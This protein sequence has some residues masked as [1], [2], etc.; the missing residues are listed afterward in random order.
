MKDCIFCKIMNGEIPSKVVYEDNKVRA[1]MDINPVVD[2][3]VL[4]IPKEHVTDYTLMT[5]ELVCHINKVAKDLGR[6]IMNKL[7]AK[8]LTMTVN[9][10]DAQEVKHYHLHLL[11]DYHISKASKDVSEIYEILKTED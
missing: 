10:G 1:I 5:D 3:H 9:Y 2:G 8:G 7:G 6:K 4:I 11:P